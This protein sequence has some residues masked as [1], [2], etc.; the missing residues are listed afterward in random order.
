MSAK[1]RAKPS[2]HRDSFMAKV[3]G[4]CPDASSSNAY[5]INR[6]A[7]MGKFRPNEHLGNHMK[8]ILLVLTLIALTTLS[9]SQKELKS[10]SS[11]INLRENPWIGNNIICVIPKSTLLTIDFSIQNSNEWIIVNYHGKI[12]YVYSKYLANP[13]LKSAFETSNIGTTQESV[14]LKYYTNSRGERVQSPTYYKT[15]PAGALA[16]CRDGT[17]SFS[18]NRRGTCSRHGGV[19]RWL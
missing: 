5:E 10:T 16:E 9:Y 12:G 17:Y 15:A 6:R 18:R 7:V 8:K 11:Y 1:T 19:K 3:P 13:N 4:P 2:L 14:H